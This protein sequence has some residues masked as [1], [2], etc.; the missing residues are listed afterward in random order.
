MTPDGPEDSKS[1]RA[2]LL[3]GTYEW[4]FRSTGARLPDVHSR[5]A[6]L[7]TA[8]AIVRSRSTPA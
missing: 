3:R 2:V 8:A 1:D 7:F 5:I 6:S 4:R